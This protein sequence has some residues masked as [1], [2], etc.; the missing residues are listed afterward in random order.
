MLIN[1]G[2]GVNSAG[3]L[4]IS[5]R[6]KPIFSAILC[7]A[8]AISSLY[9]WNRPTDR[10]VR[11]D[12]LFSALSC[13]RTATAL[14]AVAIVVAGCA[15][16]NNATSAQASAQDEQ[17]YKTMYG[18]TSDGPDHRPLHRD[19]WFAPTSART[20]NERCLGPARSA[21]RFTTG[22]AGSAGHG[23]CTPEPDRD[24]DKPAGP[25]HRGQPGAATRL[26]PAG[27]S[28]T[29]AGRTAT[30]ASCTSARSRRSRR[31]RH[32]R[33]RADH[34]SLHRDLR[35]PTQQRPITS[36]RLVSGFDILI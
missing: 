4:A 14:A 35:T 16:A 10:S 25:D 28:P 1:E 26:R 30:R 18:M 24:H 5:G 20:C 27:C 33:Q 21:R 9:C 31:I 12:V 15:A 29:G 6:S 36:S 13:I 32:H 19:F 23:G 17:P 7:L 3:P 22:H 11:G 2:F 8:R 34:R